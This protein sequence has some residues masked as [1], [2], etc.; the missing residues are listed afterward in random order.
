MKPYLEY[1]DTGGT[2]SIKVKAYAQNKMEVPVH[3]HPEHE[4]VWII[5]G[6]GKVHIADAETSFNRG[7]LFFIGGSVPHWFED[8]ADQSGMIR[9]SEVIVIQFKEHLFEQLKDFPEFDGTR[10]FLTRIQQGIKVTGMKN[11]QDLMLDLPKLEGVEKF[12][13]LTYLLDYII[14]HGKYRTI[15]SAELLPVT[16][17]IAFARLQKIHTYLTQRFQEEITIEEVAA[18]VHLSK[19]SLCRFLKKET[20]QTFSEHLNAIRVQNA[21]KLLRETTQSVTQ[22]CYGVG[23]NNAAYF[24]KQFKKLKNCSP[25]EYKNK[26]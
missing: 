22:V 9:K 7:N 17:R 21:C 20:E 18:L 1:I 13:K 4:I 11:L 26:V 14:R 5:K 24:F 12:N 16:N 25:Y 23:Y 19:T 2:S 10:S 6:R 8:E 15:A 3:Y